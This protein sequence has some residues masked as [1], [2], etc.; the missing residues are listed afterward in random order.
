M[1]AISE[2]KVVA[3]LIAGSD[4]VHKTGV[5][6]FTEGRADPH[7]FGERELAL[8]C[9]R[10]EKA[11]ARPDAGALL[12]VSARRGGLSGQANRICRR[13]CATLAHGHKGL[14]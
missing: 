10:N 13:A 12:Q 5:T 7:A 4:E 6:A 2:G 14:G 8:A 11:P 1:F 3:A 9:P